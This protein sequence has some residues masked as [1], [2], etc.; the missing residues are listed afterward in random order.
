MKISLSVSELQDTIKK[1]QKVVMNSKQTK[2]PAL[3][4]VKISALDNAITMTANNLNTVT[5]FTLFGSIQEQGEVLIPSDTLKLISKLKN[6]NYIE[7]SENLIIAGSKTL[8]FTSATVDQFPIT[9]DTCT[10][11]A[12]SIGHNELIKSLSVNYACA[13]EENRP[14]FTGVCLNK[15]TFVATDTHRMAW[16]YVES[17]NN[18][19]EKEI[20]IPLQVTKLL[21]SYLD[22]KSSLLVNV[23]ID[24]KQNHVKFEFHN[25]LIISRLIEGAFPNFKQVIPQDF[26]TSVKLNVKKILEELS[27]L[28]DIAKQSD[29]TITLGVDTEHIYFD[30]MAEN[31]AVTL[32]IDSVI[33]GSEIECMGFSYKL[34]T[35]G[36]KNV[37][38]EEVELKF[39]GPYSPLCFENA[40]VLPV[41]L[42]NMKRLNVAS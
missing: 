37:E 1:A 40:L 32:T 35:E 23:S 29:G 15:N 30:A 14:I 9:N 33:T 17:I 13:I 39:N 7:I 34:L 20:V 2:L 8:K 5:V 12:F 24:K 21:Q 42:P 36:L 10:I 6:T 3:L 22:K 25:T 19:I 28:E 41:R 4:S 31:N 18:T 27:F 11:P 38:S 16:Y 26:K